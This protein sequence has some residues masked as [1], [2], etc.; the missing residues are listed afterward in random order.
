MNLSVSALF[1]APRVSLAHRGLCLTIVQI[2]RV[3]C[4]LSI[5]PERRNELRAHGN[6]LYLTSCKWAYTDSSPSLL[7]SR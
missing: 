6:P 7:C 2:E 1:I 5:P 4:G 3:L